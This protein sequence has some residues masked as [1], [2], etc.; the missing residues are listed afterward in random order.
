[1]KIDAETL[2]LAHQLADAAAAVIR[3]AFRQKVP[4]DIKPDNSPVS[5]ADRDAERA[6]R[7]ALA[8]HRPDHGIIGEEFG[9][10]RADADW[11]WVIDPIDGT[12]S[13]LAG[14]PTFGTLIALLY[15][16]QPVLGVIDQPI[17]GDRWIG[18][19][20][21]GAWHNGQPATV[22][23]CPLLA[24]A[25]VATTGPSYFNAD[26]LAAYG[27]VLAAAQTPIWGGDCTNYAMLASGHIDIVIEQGLKLHDF[28]ALVPVVTGA[29]GRM[30]D[31]SGAPLTATSA[32]D[33]LALGDGALAVPVEALLASA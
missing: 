23:A 22:R 29:G 5:L 33:V 7:A 25:T 9:S 6:I 15:R 4:V 27:R 11:V 10:E 24:R 8:T 14:K 26:G 30:T 21:E 18:I 31:W 3:P 32:G 28:A 12:K 16:Q 19:S 20:H 13:F 2:A 1:M 17:V